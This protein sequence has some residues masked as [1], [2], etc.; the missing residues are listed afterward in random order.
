MVERLKINQIY[1]AP[2]ALR[3][4]LKSGESFV[5]KYDRSSLRTLGC[6]EY[7]RCILRADPDGDG[8]THPLTPCEHKIKAMF[9]FG[10]TIIKQAILIDA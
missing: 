3:L 1:L 9:K 2:T 8:V 10:G 7:L 6:G 5:T 4:L